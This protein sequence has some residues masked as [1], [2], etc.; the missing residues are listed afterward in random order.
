MHA[1]DIY[2]G[3]WLPGGRRP[4]TTSCGIRAKCPSE[5]R[6]PLYFVEFE[7][8]QTDLQKLISIQLDVKLK[9]KSVFL[10]RSS[11]ISNFVGSGLSA[12]FSFSI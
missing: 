7:S 11:F 1:M 9:Q 5:R 2:S 3:V 10:T 6:T 12:S 8:S 4:Y